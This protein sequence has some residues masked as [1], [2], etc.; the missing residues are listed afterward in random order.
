M[1]K[2]IVKAVCILAGALCALTVWLVLILVA[3]AIH[4]VLV[5]ILVL[6]GPGVL[7]SLSRTAPTRKQ[8][9]YR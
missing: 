7:S 1:T 4:P 8:P 5:L 2:T 3:S 6:G 9:S